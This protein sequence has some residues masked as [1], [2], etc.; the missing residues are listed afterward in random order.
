MQL[1]GVGQQKRDV[2]LLN[3][4]G[5]YSLSTYRVKSLKGWSLK[6]FVINEEISPKRHWCMSTTAGR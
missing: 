2:G 3:F 4:P 5:D 1:Q 6:E